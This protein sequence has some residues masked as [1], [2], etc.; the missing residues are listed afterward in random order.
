M[1]SLE[2]QKTGES[3]SF[4]KLYPILLTAIQ[5]VG[6][7]IAFDLKNYSVSQCWLI[8]VN[9]SIIPISSLES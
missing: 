6:F 5:T 7:E 3:G 2:A 8:G 4:T 9:L 1:G